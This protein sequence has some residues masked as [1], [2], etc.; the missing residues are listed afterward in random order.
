MVPERPLPQPLWTT[1]A[2]VVLIALAWG[3]GHGLLRWAASGTIGVDDATETV[4]AQ[5]LSPGYQT[6]QPPLYN[7]LL[8]LTQGLVGTGVVSFLILKYALLAVGTGAMHAAA[9]LALPDAR[10][11]AL[12]ALSL[13][14]LYQIGWNAHEGVTHSAALIATTLLA[15]AGFMAMVARPSLP[16]ALAFGAAA[17]LGMLSKHGFPAALALMAVG[18]L[19]TPT[20]RARLRPDL[21]LA[22]AAVAG[23]IY[24]PYGLWLAAQEGGVL[25]SAD[26]TLRAREGPGA[27]V[28]ALRALAMPVLFLSPLAPLLLALRLWGSRRAGP[29]PAPP[30]ADPDWTGFLGAATAAAVVGLLVA[31]LALNLTTLKERHMHPL[32]LAAPLWLWAWALR[33]WGGVPPVRACAGALLGLAALALALRAAGL[34]IPGP[35]FCPGHCRPVKPFDALGPALLADG[36]GTAT[37]V[38]GDPFV[39]GNL[40]RLLPQA[41]I[42]LPTAET[43]PPAL[44]AARLQCRLVWDRD[45]TPAPA[46][47]L[48]P[49]PGDGPT[50]E[51]DQGWPHPWNPP[52]WRLSRFAMRALDPADPRC[53]ID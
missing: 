23:L 18:A 44:G 14:A 29:A 32:F 10:A 50:R 36:A 51:I 35:P 49:A 19:A 9:R 53:A 7:W 16:R 24:A 52:G 13:S 3:A 2:G 8:H 38:A 4:Y 12:A 20:V 37:L 28:M 47:L 25:T 5:T 27:A 46:F 11:A 42:V 45:V 26:Q 34:L 1:P 48:D 22:A 43:T 33:P 21:L 31:T 6:L 39:A 17:G 30:P 40:R 15:W 41:R